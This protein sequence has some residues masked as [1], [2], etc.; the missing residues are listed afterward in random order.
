MHVSG[1]NRAASIKDGCVLLSTLAMVY[2]SIVW[3]AHEARVAINEP[4]AFVHHVSTSR[5]RLNWRLYVCTF[6][7]PC[8]N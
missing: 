4:Y 5:S 3:G 6:D 7:P 1:R 2:C 8:N